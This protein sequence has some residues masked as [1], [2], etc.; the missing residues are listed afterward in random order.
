MVSVRMN[1]I[2]RW[3]AV[4]SVMSVLFNSALS[5]QEPQ[6]QTPSA[7]SISSGGSQELNPEQTYLFQVRFDRAPVGFAGGRIV[8][9]F[10]SNPED[11]CKYQNSDMKHEITDTVPLQDG[12]SVYNIY[13]PLQ[14]SMVRCKWKLSKLQIGVGNLQDIPSKDSAEFTVVDAPPVQVKVT[15][16]DK[17]TAG[18]TLV[19]HFTMDRFPPARGCDPPTLTGTMS[20]PPNDPRKTSIPLPQVA[21]KEGQNAYEMPVSMGT[22][23]PGGTYQGKL[24]FWLPAYELACKMPGLR[25]AEFHVTID[26]APR[27]TA[28]TSAS[29]TVNPSQVQLLLGEADRLR[30][31]ASNLS[32]EFKQNPPQEDTLRNRLKEVMADVDQTDTKFRAAGD[33]SISPRAIG[34]FFDDIRFEYG[35]VLKLLSAQSSRE[36]APHL[37]R[38]SIHSP[39]NLTLASDKLTGAMLHAS[40]AYDI[41]AS[42]RSLTFNLE[43]VSFP[44]GGR[45]SY[46][47]RGGQYRAADHD[48]DWQVEGLTVGV[49]QICV[50]KAGYEDAEQDFDATSNKRTSITFN[51]VRKRTKQ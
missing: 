31:Q 24:R 49:W 20:L 22:D 21:V 50:Q 10:Y 14:S 7:A 27:V 45:I 26:P 44:H 23:V 37:L 34:T 42:T 29:F 13:E 51:L 38:T 15:V 39:V 25:G 43:V 18:Q 8:Y 9:T 6:K 28:P 33:G 36:M 12:Q 4:L 16:P 5:A 30:A 19:I 32:K 46:R 3:F 47:Q 40:G 35:E 11:N 41:V 17:V 48:T 2:E 1:T